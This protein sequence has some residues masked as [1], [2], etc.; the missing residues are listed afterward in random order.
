MSHIPALWT[1]SDDLVLK[2]LGLSPLSDAWQTKTMIAGREDAK[3]EIIFNFLCLNYSNTIPGFSLG[4]VQDYLHA[5]STCFLLGSRHCKAK[6]HVSLVFLETLRQV[7]TSL[8]KMSWVET[9]LTTVVASLSVDVS[10]A[11]SVSGEY[12]IL[13]QI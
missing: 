2:L 7:R 4:F 1:S 8:I 5:Y 12:E 11:N 3:P 10:T 13:D 6:L 9:C